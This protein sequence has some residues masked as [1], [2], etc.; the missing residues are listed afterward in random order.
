MDTTNI[1]VNIISFVVLFA[2]TA[3]VYVDAKAIGTDRRQTPGLVKTSPGL[4][5]TGVFLLLIVFLPLYLIMRV[6]YKRLAL[7]RKA[8]QA[9]AGLEYAEDVPGVWP[10]PPQTPTP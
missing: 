5:A 1:V 10:P 9:E 2:I 8:L 7:Q 4:W 6:R 3:W